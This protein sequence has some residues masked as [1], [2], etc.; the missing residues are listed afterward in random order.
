MLTVEQIRDALSDRH[1]RTVAERVGLTTKAL[2]N[3]RA[4]KIKR[5]HRATLKVLS[6]YLERPL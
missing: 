4:G 5:P 2:E 6:E 3:I 1:L